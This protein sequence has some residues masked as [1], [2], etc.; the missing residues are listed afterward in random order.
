MATIKMREN[1]KGIVFQIK[2]YDHRLKN[3][4]ATMTYKPDEN[5]TLK[6]ARKEAE[7]QAVKFEEKIQ[8]EIILHQQYLK[9]NKVLLN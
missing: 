5:M 4:E 6:Q 9:L 2:V 1:K 8:Q 3:S 7:R